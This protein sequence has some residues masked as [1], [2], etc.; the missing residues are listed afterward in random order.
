IQDEN[1]FIGAYVATIDITLAGGSSVCETDPNSPCCYTCAAGPPSGCSSDPACNNPI[2]QDKI[3][4]RC[5]QQKRRVGV[6]FMYP[7]QR[8]VNAL[9]LSTDLTGG[10]KPTPSDALVFLEA[11]VGVPWQD[12]A[13]PATLNDPSALEYLSA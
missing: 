1:G 4:L 8:Y 11:I 3:N 10:G 13:T 7:T 9:P 6:D 5:W 12:L 2:A